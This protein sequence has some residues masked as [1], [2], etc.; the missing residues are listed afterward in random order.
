MHSMKILKRPYK[1]SL[2]NKLVNLKCPWVD[3]VK[4]RV[5]KRIAELEAFIE[6]E[7][8]S[9]GIPFYKDESFLYECFVDNKAHGLELDNLKVLKFFRMLLKVKLLYTMIGVWKFTDKDK[10]MYTYFRETKF[11]SFNC[12]KVNFYFECNSGVEPQFFVHDDS[13]KWF[14]DVDDSGNR[15]VE[16][17]VNLFRRDFVLLDDMVRNVKSLYTNLPN[18]RMFDGY[19]YPE[20]VGL[21][22]DGTNSCKVVQSS[23]NALKSCL[24]ANH[25][26]INNSEMVKEKKRIYGVENRDKIL[27]KHK[28]YRED[29]IDRIR[30]YDRDRSKK[31][32][33]ERVEYMKEYSE[34]NRER[35]LQ[36]KREYHYKNRDRL[37]K[38]HRKYYQDNKDKLNESSKLYREKNKDRIAKRVTEWYK[39]KVAQ[40]YRKRKDPVTGKYVWVFVGNN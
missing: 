10:E 28:K 25:Y 39:E 36:Q 19:K 6:R 12:Y 30:E 11:N 13:C 37:L 16:H 7:A 4:E 2:Y 26:R 20:I 34:K 32:S 38:Q 9:E 21:V 31:R 18:D 22:E 33:E 40:G 1:I 15:S 24:N 5:T 35:I 23:D 29:N 14:I 3:E 17:F 27:A 8:E